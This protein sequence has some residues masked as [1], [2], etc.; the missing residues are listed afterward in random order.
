MASEREGS[1]RGAEGS[2]VGDTGTGAGTGTGTGDVSPM[3]RLS[4]VLTAAA[5]STEPTPRELAE[6]LWL[7]GQLD[8]AQGAPASSEGE[9]RPARPAPDAP[10]VVPPPR[11]AS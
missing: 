5:G 2:S 8:G 4:A 9:P 11:P 7:A 3:A 6:L 1:P 10:A